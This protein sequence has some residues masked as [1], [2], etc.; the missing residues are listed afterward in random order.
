[1]GKVLFILLVIASVSVAAVFFYPKNRSQSN[2]VSVVPTTVP[3]QTVESA[4]LPSGEDV[5]RTFFEL[6]NEKRI[7]EAVEMFAPSTI[8]DD[9]AKQAWG[10]S[11]NHFRS[12]KAEVIEKYRQ[13]SWTPTLQIYKVTLNIQTDAPAQEIIW[14]N[15]TNTRWIELTKVNNLWKIVGLATGP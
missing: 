12:V 15:G 7:P 9:T 4:P 10:V 2:H 3:S 8:P 13:D 6:I 1:V 5:I 14:E 11:F